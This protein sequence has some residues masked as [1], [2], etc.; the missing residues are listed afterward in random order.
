MIE[1]GIQAQP[2]EV[3][4]HAASLEGFEMVVAPIHLSPANPHLLQARSL[5][6]RI[7]SHHQAVGELMMG[8]IPDDLLKIEVTGTHSKTT[9]ALLLAMILSH[10]KRVLSH[11][12]RGLEVWSGGRPRLLR[13]G[14]SI[15]P[16]NVILAAEAAL[17]QGAEALICEISLGGTG[18]A[19]LGILT[20]FAHDYRIAAGSRWASSAKLQMLSLARRGSR[21]AANSDCNISPDISFAQGGRVQALPDGLIYGEVRLGLSLGEDLDFASYQTAISAASAAAELLGLERE[22]TIRALEGFGG[23]S[24]R[25]KIERLDGRMVFDSSNSGLKV[26]DIERALDRAQGPDLVAVIGE[27]A[28]TVCEGLDVPLLADLLR[29]RRMEF[30]KLVLVGERLRPLA[31]ELGAETAQDLAEGL[32]KVASLCPKRL[33]S[34][35][36]CFR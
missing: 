33:L 31:A 11:T 32:E 25:M 29:R 26:S 18:L 28:R 36:K 10:Q 15:T 35:V 5:G 22:E 1:C 6:K 16:A 27:D 9:T 21:L 4:H 12:T 13:A 34:A 2:L 8:S 24:G 3:Y 19:E 23:F 20:S 17:S 30:Y 14:L 7:I